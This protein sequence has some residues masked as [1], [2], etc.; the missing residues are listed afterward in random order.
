[1]VETADVQRHGLETESATPNVTTR[2][3]NTTPVIVIFPQ[4][5]TL[6]PVNVPIVILEM[7]GM[8]PSVT[9]RLV[10]SMAETVN[11]WRRTSAQLATITLC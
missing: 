6:D 4:A 5:V 2:N 7:V 9:R 1:M 10:R 3:A 8:I 11:S